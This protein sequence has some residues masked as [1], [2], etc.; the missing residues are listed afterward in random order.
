MLR[1]MTDAAGGFYSTQDADSE[2]EEGKFFLWTP[3]E[4]AAVLGEDAGESSAATSAYGEA[5]TSRAATS[6]TSDAARAS[7]PRRRASSRS[8]RDGKGEALRGARAAHPPRPRREG[9]HGLE[10]PHAARLR[11]SRAR[12]R[13]A[14][15]RDAAV[16]NAE[17]LLVI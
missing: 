11:R 9:A 6:S 8:C 1:E 16:H 12:L 5:A 4:L 10:R 3:A 14:R 17:F 2:G 7:P 15:Y 13:P